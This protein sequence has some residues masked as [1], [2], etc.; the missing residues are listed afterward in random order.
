MNAYGDIIKNA[1]Q[2]WKPL[3]TRPDKLLSTDGTARRR[4]KIGADHVG[5]DGILRRIGNPPSR[6][7][8]S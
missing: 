2:G 7:P 3:F 4:R 8:N 5:Q 1:Q 6:I